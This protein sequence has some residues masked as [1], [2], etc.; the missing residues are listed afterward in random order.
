MNTRISGD[1]GSYTVE[2]ALLLPLFI[3]AVLALA[4]TMRTV[5]VAGSAMHIATDEAGRLALDAYASETPA[6]LSGRV[7][8]RIY[9]ECEDV[10]TV[11]LGSLRYRYTS[12]GVEDLISF[13]VRTE[14]VL[15][16]PFPRKEA[17]TTEHALLF[18]AWTGT[19]AAGP[20]MGF[21][22][23]E[24][25]GGSQTVWVFPQ[26]GT[27]YHGENCTY[28]ASRPVQRLLDEDLKKHYAP[29]GSCHPED[30]PD[31]SVVYCYPNYG[32]SYHRSSCNK[33]DK[34]VVSME[35][36]DATARGYVPCSKCGGQ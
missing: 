18:R 17:A 31:G 16:L 23:M 5:G 29:C 10:T 19:R 25:E 32:E 36:E 13:R 22:A 8:E 26:S 7:E 20:A 35:K 3:L 33:V 11:H 30:L 2:A 9:R 21:A 34:Y 24:E 27:H 15:P 28:V 4:F 12:G 6:L 1:R 14:V